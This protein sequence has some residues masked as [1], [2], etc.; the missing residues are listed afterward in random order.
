MGTANISGAVQAPMVAIVARR[1]IRSGSRPM[2][3]QATTISA[4]PVQKAKPDSV[5]P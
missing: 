3:T 4:M 1:L 2:R 5:L